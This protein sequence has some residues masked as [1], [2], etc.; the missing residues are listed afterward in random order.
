MLQLERKEDD[1]ALFS[2]FIDAITERASTTLPNQLTETKL[3]YDNYTSRQANSFESSINEMFQTPGASLK[4]LTDSNSQA[5]PVIIGNSLLSLKYCA[6]SDRTRATMPPLRLDQDDEWGFSR[7]ESSSSPTPDDDCEFQNSPLSLLVVNSLQSLPPRLISQVDLVIQDGS[8]VETREFPNKNLFLGQRS[9]IDQAMLQRPTPKRVVQ[10]VVP[11]AD[12]PMIKEEDRTKV[13]PTEP[14]RSHPKRTKKAKLEKE[15]KS[16]ELL[17]EATSDDEEWNRSTKKRKLKRK[18]KRESSSDDSADEY[19]D[20]AIIEDERP[21]RSKTG[22]RIRSAPSKWTPEEDERLKALVEEIPECINRWTQI[23]SRLGR[24]PS[25]CFQ[26]WMRV[27][28]PDINKGPWSLEEE[29]KLLKLVQN[30]SGKLSWAK[31]A[32]NF[33]GRTDTQCRYQFTRIKRSQEVPWTEEEDTSLK[34][35]TNE[36]AVQNL[37]WS[38]LAN[39]H[40]K[41]LLKNATTKYK[42]PPRGPFDCRLRWSI[43]QDKTERKA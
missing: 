11:I 29:E 35:V 15:Q 37:N 2:H 36:A 1:C 27:L 21:R 19:V 30:N 32:M 39:Q 22:P 42:T 17:E 6:N 23:G 31:I 3:R 40:Y 26:H 14:R 12:S 43:L 25:Q 10:A 16:S 34:T 4:R 38:D 18:N 9:G 8:L 41:L 33:P 5:R 28:N 20:D 7:R 24:S 13:Q